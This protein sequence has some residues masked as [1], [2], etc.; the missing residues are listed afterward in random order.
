MTIVERLMCK[1]GLHDWYVVDQSW[2]GDIDVCIA[3]TFD[4][5]G[6]D[7]TRRPSTDGGVIESRVCL[8]CG[9]TED[10]IAEYTA[11]RHLRMSRVFHLLGPGHVEP[12]KHKRGSCLPPPKTP[13]GF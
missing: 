6:D 13:R 7:E 1:I 11:Q 12:R 9:H 2:T 8:R 10:K 4:P 3:N 5:L